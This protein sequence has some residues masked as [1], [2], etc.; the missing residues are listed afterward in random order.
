MLTEKQLAGLAY[1]RRGGYWRHTEEWKKQRSEFMRAHNPMKRLTG[2]QHPSW[3]R[4]KLNC[5]LCGCEIWRPRCLLHRSKNHF[6]SVECKR[7]W[8]FE[9]R[10]T[11]PY[12][13]YGKDWRTIRNQVLERDDFRCVECGLK[14]R[15]EIHHRDKWLKSKNNGNNNL[16]TLCRSCHRLI[17]PRHTAIKVTT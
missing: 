9:N 4:R 2:I 10:K 5:D 8:Q 1:G 12:Y 14:D 7:K 6:C 17:E 15:L 16:V 13:Y 11:H 3:T